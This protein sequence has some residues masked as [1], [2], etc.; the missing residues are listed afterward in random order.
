MATWR[1]DFSFCC[2]CWTCL[3]FVAWNALLKAS[4]FL[5]HDSVA[6][7]YRDH[8][9]ID[10][11]PSVPCC[12][13]VSLG[14]TNPCTLVLTIPRP[15]GR[16]INETRFPELPRYPSSETKYGL[17]YVL[18]RVSENGSCNATSVWRVCVTRRKME[19]SSL[20]EIKCRRD[21]L[22]TLGKVSTSGSTW[23]LDWVLSPCLD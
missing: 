8:E 11:K 4:N 22:E 1:I 6:S 21:A 14:Y 10:A 7:R 3:H 17:N 13:E 20:G 5:I 18:A 23:N 16:N 19:F 12:T 9:T 2:W 15:L